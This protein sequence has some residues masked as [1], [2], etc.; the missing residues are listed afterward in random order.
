MHTEFRSGAAVRVRGGRFQVLSADKI[1][2]G[3]GEPICRLR[4]RALDEPFRNEE[5]CVLHPLEDVEPDAIPEL[6][7]ARPGRLARFQLLMDAV[8]LSL[9]PGDDRLVSSTRSRIAFEPYQQV[10]ALRALELPRPR[11]LIAD[12]VGL[13]Q[14]LDRK[15][16][17]LNSSH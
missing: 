2:Q 5:I 10:P 3:N 11:L 9:A 1:A 7:L 14:T 12:D 15:S 16:T 4:L 6:D 17:R 13:G 8:R